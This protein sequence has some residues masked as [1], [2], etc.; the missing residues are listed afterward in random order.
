MININSIV[1]NALNACGVSA[2]R[3]V[4]LL[5]CR[6]QINVKGR[7]TPIYAPHVNVYAQVQKLASKEKYADGA[8]YSPEAYKFW[9]S[10]NH[11]KL[12]GSECGADLIFADGR[13]YAVKEAVDDF[14]DNGW[15]SVVAYECAA[16]ETAEKS[17]CAV[18]AAVYDF[19]KEHVIAGGVY[20]AGQNGVNAA[21]EDE[22]TLFSVIKTAPRGTSYS[23]FY[24]SAD[25][26]IMSF[27]KTVR[28]CFYGS[29]AEENAEKLAVLFNSSCGADFFKD[30]GVGALYSEVCSEGF[31]RTE[32]LYNLPQSA[33]NIYIGVERE[34]QLSTEY[35]DSVSIQIK[36]PLQ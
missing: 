10:G 5:I 11:M 15:Q 36:E 14:L 4:S 13:Y 18:R 1:S 29:N 20:L 22:Y 34:V 26:Q 19:L 24:K 8:A 9:L 23:K 33:L 16:P 28:V 21:Y 3:L 30:R 2:H 27:I 32:N 17:V 25:A 6:A 31:M 35:F 7:L 12:K